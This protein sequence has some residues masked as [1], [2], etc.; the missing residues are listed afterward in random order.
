MT[1]YGDQCIIKRVKSDKP[2]SP[3]FR[4]EITIGG[5][6]YKSSLWV[7]D[8]K[9]GTLVLDKNGEKQLK[10]KVEVDNWTPGGEQPK[11]DAGKVG[12][13]GPADDD[14]IPFAPD[15]PDTF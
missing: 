12:G 9:D 3:A 7:W 6:K 4:A 15:A 13:S 5:R 1:D 8:K 14:S 10:G 2:N 11:A